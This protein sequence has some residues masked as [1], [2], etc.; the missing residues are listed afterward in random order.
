M[1]SQVA[2]GRGGL[3]SVPSP[4]NQLFGVGTGRDG[5]PYPRPTGAVSGVVRQGTGLEPGLVRVKQQGR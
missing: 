5:P 1:V 3:L 4:V 2:K